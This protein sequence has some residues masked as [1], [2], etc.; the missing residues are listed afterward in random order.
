MNDEINN[1]GTGIFTYKENCND[2][3]SFSLVDINGFC[4]DCYIEDVEVENKKFE[5]ILEKE[6]RQDKY[7]KLK[8]VL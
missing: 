4:Q 7:E 6:D 1:I 5:K 3:G 8:K 2:C